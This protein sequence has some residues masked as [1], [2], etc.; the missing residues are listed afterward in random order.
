M[1]TLESP[2]KQPIDAQAV[3]AVVKEA[4]RRQRRRRLGIVGIIT[5]LL[6]ATGALFF[7]ISGDS[8]GDRLGTPS[9]RHEPKPN[10]PTASPLVP[11]SPRALAPHEVIRTLVRMT[12]T[13]SGFGPPDGGNVSILGLA[14]QWTNEGSTCLQV[15]MGA[16]V[17]T[18]V[19][20]QSAW[21]ATGLSLAPL[22]DNRQGF[23]VANIFGGGALPYNAPPSV[24]ESA[25]LLQQRFG[26]HTALLHAIP[27]IPGVIRVGRQR[28]SVGAS[29]LGFA[30]GK[31]PRSP[32]V[33][34]DPRSGRLL[35]ARYVTAGSLYDSVGLGIFSVSLRHG[36]WRPEHASVGFN[37]G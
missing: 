18:S 16:P 13:V 11:G 15:A 27:L 20:Q 4:R 24:T 30:T 7:G 34:L 2:L 31:G 14:Q 1:I 3:Q 32:L 6:L 36:C 9:G 10:S 5:V 35:E 37:N 23:C 8:G 12:L 28:S 26:S 25:R 22:K 17:V 19:A 29:A 33:V 21:L